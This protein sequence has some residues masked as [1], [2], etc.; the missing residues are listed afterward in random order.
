MLLPD[1]FIGG[2]VFGNMFCSGY[3]ISDLYSDALILGL[4]VLD[5]IFLGVGSDV[6]LLGQVFL[7][8][9]PIYTWICILRYVIPRTYLPI[10][11]HSST[12]VPR[13]V[14]SRTC[15]PG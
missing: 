5:I 11:V 10:R 6:L 3:F 15:I 1:I 13:Y 8:D 4:A 7:A 12:C 9:N 14:I 2:F